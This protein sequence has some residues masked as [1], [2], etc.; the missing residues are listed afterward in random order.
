MSRLGRQL[1]ELL[2]VQRNRMF[3]QR[4]HSASVVS[5]NQHGEFSTAC[6][7]HRYKGSLCFSS[8]SP[9]CILSWCRCPTLACCSLCPWRPLVD[10]DL[11]S[12]SNTDLTWSKTVV[13]FSAPPVI[14]STRPAP[15]L[16]A[17]LLPTQLWLP[18]DKYDMSCIKYS[19]T[20]VTTGSLWNIFEI[21]V[22]KNN[23][24]HLLWFLVDTWSRVSFV[25]F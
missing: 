23:A 13:P 8:L 19:G 9:M 15:A 25:L 17:K 12:L 21:S 7:I 24:D 22:S 20:V 3:Q 10:L 18:V 14:L 2:L 11:Q 4:S 16:L 1:E 6:S 5:T